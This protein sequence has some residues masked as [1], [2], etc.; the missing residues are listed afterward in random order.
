MRREGFTGSSAAWA[1]LLRLERV[2]TKPVAVTGDKARYRSRSRREIVMG[3]LR[4]AGGQP[5]FHQ[6]GGPEDLIDRRKILVIM[7]NC[8]NG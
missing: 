2:V 8:L 4:L 5:G 7:T 3:V 6:G 1:Q